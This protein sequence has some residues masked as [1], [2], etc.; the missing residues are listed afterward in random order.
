MLADYK[1]AGPLVITWHF[2]LKTAQLLLALGVNR[3]NRR[4]Y[5]SPSMRHRTNVSI[6]PHIGQDVADQTE[7]SSRHRN[8][9]VNETGLFETSDVI[10]TYQ[11]I[12]KRD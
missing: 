7:T 5:Y 3:S 10:T 1:T 11:L 9:Y 8:R 12:P 6:R 2:K 4:I